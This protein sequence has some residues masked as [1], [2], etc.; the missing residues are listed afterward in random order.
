MTETVIKLKNVNKKFGN[1]YNFKNNNIKLIGI[2][3]NIDVHS[4]YRG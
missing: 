2:V 4:Y 1:F 3:I